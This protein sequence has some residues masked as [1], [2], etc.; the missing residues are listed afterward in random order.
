MNSLTSSPVTDGLSSGSDVISDRSPVVRESHLSISSAEN[1]SES[2]SGEKINSENHISSQE[3][4]KESKPPNP[5]HKQDCQNSSDVSNVESETLTVELKPSEK[6]STTSP[7]LVTSNEY[8]YHVKWIHFRAR[9]IPIITQNE[10]GPCP[11]IA[12]SNVLLLK[13]VISLPENTE[14]VTGERLTRMLTDLLF[15]SPIQDLE[16]GQRLNYEKTVFDALVLF[17]SLQTGLDVNVRF[18]D[19]SAFEFTSVLGVF[20]LFEI[21][22]YHGWLVDPRDAELASIVGDRTYNRLVEEIIHLKASSNPDDVQKGLLADNFLQQTASQLTYHGLEELASTLKEGQLAVLFRNNHFCT[23]TKDKGQIYVLVTDMGLLN[24][25]DVVWEALCDV[26]GNTRF[27]DA[28]FGPYKPTAADLNLEHSLFTDSTAR[29]SLSSSSSTRPVPNDSSDVMKTPSSNATLPAKPSL[30]RTLLGNTLGGDAGAGSKKDTKSVSNK[31]T[32]K[33]ICPTNET[34]KM[35]RKL[36]YSELACACTNLLSS[37]ENPE[38]SPSSDLNMAARLQL[39]EIE[40]VQSDVRII[41]VRTKKD[42]KPTVPATSG[43]SLSLDNMK[44]V[45]S[46]DLL[47]QA[48][49]EW[50]SGSDFDLALRLQYEEMQLMQDTAKISAPAGAAAPRRGIATQDAANNRSAAANSSRQ[51]STVIV[52]SSQSRRFCVSS[53]QKSNPPVTTTTD[54]A[55]DEEKGSCSLM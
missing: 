4:A 20:D 25:P 52:P 32:T 49:K 37:E 10:N 41:S 42:E 8:I 51:N 22:L 31:S 30:L 1:P 34:P 5:I 47:E 24:E 14:V 27:V 6:P 40:S 48:M 9:S 38:Q 19:V 3:N 43:A 18:T 23:V 16:A 44:E 29:S 54:H 46:P 39:E 15:S 33:Y 26:D 50:G 13:N 36:S 11:L 55:S 21:S 45:C 7:Q 17:P 28:A 53:G 35:E 12:I 2:N